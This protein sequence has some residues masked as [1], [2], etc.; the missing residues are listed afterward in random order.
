MA[1]LD[2]LATRFGAEHV[3]GGQ[4][5]IST[6]LDAEGRVRHLNELHLLTFGERDGAHSARAQTIAAALSGAKFDTRLSDNI[7][8]EMWEKWIFIAAGAGI[9][10]LMRAAIGD[11]VAAGAGDLATDLFDECAAIAAAQGVA[12]RPE[13]LARMRPSFTVPGSVLTASMLRD[14]EQGGRVEADHILGDLLRRGAGAKPIGHSLLR[15]A[16]AH[17]KAYEAR[18]LRE[19]A[20]AEKADKA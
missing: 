5:L 9:S 15:I 13:F 8:Q 11:T 20:A 12:P 19:Q 6:T 17:V 3:L 1:H 10:C 14:I 18:R 4:C 7:L 2:A 16:T